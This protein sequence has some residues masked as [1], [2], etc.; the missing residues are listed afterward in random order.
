M[1]LE[2]LAQ[3]PQSASPP[4]EEALR[5][6][7][8]ADE[9]PTLQAA[10]R[11]RLTEICAAGG[12][13][14]ARLELREGLSFVVWSVQPGKPPDRHSRGPSRELDARHLPR[15]QASPRGEDG[16]CPSF[17]FTLLDGGRPV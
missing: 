5:I 6:W 2:L 13:D 10:A 12:W 14:A 17:L 7:R 4:N 9:A 3:T 1:A 16:S 11:A 15:W 8:I